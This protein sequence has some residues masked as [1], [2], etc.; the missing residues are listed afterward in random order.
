M[1]MRRITVILMALLLVGTGCQTQQQQDKPAAADKKLLPPVHLGAVHQVYPEQGFA[2]LRIIGPMPKG[3]TVLISH[4]AD[5][6]ND[7]IGNLIVSTDYT[8]RGN[9]ITADIRSGAVMRGDRVFLYR[10]IVPGK[11]DANDAESEAMAGEHPI[12]DSVTDEQVAAARKQ[13]QREEAT[14]ASDD[15]ITETPAPAATPTAEPEPEPTPAPTPSV[16]VPSYLD[17]IPD[18][19]H[20]WN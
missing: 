6:S 3:G 8:P 2:L 14:A 16:E 9:I 10:S 4:P 1:D 18:D 19:I 12:L 15:T 20:G 11:K 7:R 13:R 5:G 17:D